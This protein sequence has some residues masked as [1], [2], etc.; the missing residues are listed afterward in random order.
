MT[1]QKSTLSMN[2]LNNKLVEICCLQMHEK[3]NPQ[4]Q[5]GGVF[6]SKNPDDLNRE[7]R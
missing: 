2:L 7:D 1:A 6:A 3:I 5:C 4:N